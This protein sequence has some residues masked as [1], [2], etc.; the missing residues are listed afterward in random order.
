MIIPARWYSG[1]KGLDEFRSQMLNDDRIAEIHDFPETSEV[2]PGL[3]IRGGVCYFLWNREN[4]GN[5]KVVNYKQGASND[6]IIRPLLEPNADIFI[7]YNQAISILH[8]VR[9]L[10]EKLFEDF[11]STQKPFG[12]RTFV[13]G[14]SKPLPN[15]IKLYQNGGVGYVS[16]KEISKNMSWID[17]VKVIVPRSSPGSDVYPHQVIGQPI[18]SEPGSACTETYIV[19]GPLKNEKI[20]KNVMSYM[21]TKFFRFLM[22]LIKNTQDVPRR[23]YSFIPMQNFNENWSDEKLFKKYGISNEEEQF[24]NLL[25]RPMQNDKE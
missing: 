11:V 10:N 7:R 16:K 2:F 15:S 4:K 18:L 17:K 1:G 6:A 21:R 5:C 20:A 14:Q 3:N 19:I 13:K 25:V 8:K 22:I 12:L 23:V 24:I 9:K